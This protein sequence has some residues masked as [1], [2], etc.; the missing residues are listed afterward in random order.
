MSV[1]IVNALEMI[2]I[3]QRDA[4]GR[5]VGASAVALTCHC[6]VHSFE[7]CTPIRQASEL[8]AGSKRLVF[9]QG[10]GEL[11]SLLLQLTLQLADS[12]RES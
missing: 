2:D 8:I 3:D 9:L 11:I 4:H 1:L 7:R 10:F 6:F 5:R 12:D